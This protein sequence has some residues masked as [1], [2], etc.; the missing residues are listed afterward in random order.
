MKETKMKRKKQT[1]LSQG[2]DRLLMDS[3]KKLL[4]PGLTQTHRPKTEREEKASFLKDAL[5][6][7]ILNSEWLS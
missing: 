5:N 4:G 1:I 6:S 2:Q 7:K 3:L